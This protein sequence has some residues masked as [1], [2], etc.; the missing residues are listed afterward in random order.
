MSQKK[1]SDIGPS[2]RLEKGVP[3]FFDILTLVAAFVV[4]FIAL[5]T[6]IFY[7]IRD[8]IRLCARVVQQPLVSLFE[9]PGR[10]L[11]LVASCVDALF[12]APIRVMRALASGI[13]S[14]RLPR[15]RPTL[16]R[17]RVK[18]PAERT[19]TRIILP[20]AWR[21]RIAAF[22][23]VAFAL[24]LPFAMIPII[25]KYS[26]VRANALFEAQV[27]LDQMQQ[28]KESIERK[29]FSQAA[30][31]AGAALGHFSQAQE[32]THQVN[33]AVR[34]GASLV[35][36]AGRTVASGQ[37]LLQ[38]ATLAADLAVRMSAIGS[39]IA[40]G[41]VV[42]PE[43]LLSRIG[44][45]AP[46]I[47]YAHE[48]AARI[49]SLVR[50]IHERDLPSAYRDTFA[51]LKTQSGS[52]V[53]ILG[54]LQSLSD[55]LVPA[56]GFE[57][58]R[59]Y[60]F[61]FQN[62]TELR[63]SGGFIGSFALVDIDRGAITRIEVPGGGS[64]DLAGGLSERLAPPLPLRRLTGVWQFQDANWFADFP[65]T[66]KKLMWFYERSGGSTVDGVIAL[67]ASL[68]EKILLLTGPVPMQKY[69]KI[70]TAENFIEETQK[71]VELEY[72]KTVNKPKAFIADLVP[73]ALGRLSDLDEVGTRTL[74][75]VILS[76]IMEREIQAYFSSAPLQQKISAFGLSGEL[77]QS[78]DDTLLITDA[79]VAGNKS[80]RAIWA[81]VRHRVTI[82]KNGSLTT[83]VDLSKQH[84][85]VLDSPFT[86]KPSR[87]FIRFTVPLGAK[88]VSSNGFSLPDSGLDRPL[89]DSSGEDEEIAPQQRAIASMG[90]G[91]PVVSY[92]EGGR[93]V[94]A[95]FME[96]P[97][98]GTTTVTIQYQLPFKLT[99]EERR[100]SYVLAL[101]RQSG[102]RITDY[103]LSITVPKTM[104]AKWTYPETSSNA[105]RWR[106]TPWTRDQ[107]F[108]VQF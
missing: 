105:L 101:Q 27:G 95:G 100:K 22:V 2:E 106:A 49:S 87:S 7:D 86:G 54:S 78:R 77:M 64:Y 36:V 98:G 65:Q 97:L 53:Q 25:S 80:D 28:W 55:V 82:E 32:L 11:G 34:T 17:T 62:N 39:Q 69:N 23:L 15:I 35:P 93:T 21:T 99:D 51:S 91:T 88:L 50:P 18:T 38:A 29:D 107:I 13:R 75:S 59:R 47:A 12:I 96:A 67:N 43:L 94:F 40:P 45:L 33:A 60:L 20:A 52:L 8:A 46:D 3:V 84:R 108:A 42:V 19:I 30:T 48:T 57:S 73:E 56:L 103:D 4:F 92:D 6:R 104:K 83:T 26:A 89:L 79:N 41:G 24:F 37:S 61:V 16:P 102:S 31:Y 5:I 68:F 14:L 74:G 81:S 44:A 71:S 63:P 72:D 90:G 58:K 70:I 76:A 66:A 10:A 85:G 9:L 1:G